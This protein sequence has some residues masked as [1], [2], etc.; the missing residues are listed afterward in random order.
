V[1]DDGSQPFGYHWYFNSSSNYS[2]ATALADNGVHYINATT[3]EVTVTNLTGADDGYYFVVIT[4]NYG[5][6][7]SSLASLTVNM[8]PAIVSQSPAAN[9]T[10]FVNQSQTFS[11]AASGAA[12]LDYQWFTNGVADTTAGTNSTYLLASVQMDMSG[13]TYQCVVT[14]TSGSATGA[15]VTLTV[16]PLPAALTHSLYGSNILTLDPLGY[17]PMHEMEPA[18]SGDIETNYGSL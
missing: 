2:G 7:T 6:A 3:S 1:L 4:N 13:N 15:L 14:N 18:A 10:L 9:F 5:S 8:T 12:P 16:L 11:V 17:W